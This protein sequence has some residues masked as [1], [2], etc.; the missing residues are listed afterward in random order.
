[1]PNRLISSIIAQQ[2]PVIADKSTSVFTA[3]TLMTQHKVSAVMVVDAGQLIGIFTERDCLSRVITQ[4]KDPQTTTVEEVM[5]ASPITIA[6]SRPLGHALHMMND[7]GFRH[8]PIVDNGVPVGII[9]ARDALGI[10][11][12]AFERELRQREEITELLG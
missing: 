10:D 11:M 3:A 12:M 1:M 4:H 6:S 5:T 7:Y 9:S 8:M 2:T